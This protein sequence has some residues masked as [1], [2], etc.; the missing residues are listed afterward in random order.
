MNKWC[1]V[2]GNPRTNKKTET[3]RRENSWE[4]SWCE[5]KQR[6][7]GLSWRVTGLSGAGARTT[8]RKGVEAESPAPEIN[9][10]GLGVWQ[11]HGSLLLSQARRGARWASK[12]REIQHLYQ[13]PSLAVP[14]KLDVNH[15]GFTESLCWLM[16]TWYLPPGAG[17]AWKAW[18]QQESLPSRS[19]RRRCLSAEESKTKLTCLLLFRFSHL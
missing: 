1:Q 18:T 10:S 19:A 16:G 15:D 4:K 11:D 13:Q 3:V 2:Q 9:E 17:R 8:I 7:G 12:R 5:E 14:A 6:K